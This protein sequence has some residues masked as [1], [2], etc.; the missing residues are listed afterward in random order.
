M[1]ITLSCRDCRT[2]YL[3]ANESSG[4]KLRCPKCSMDLQV[5]G[6]APTPRA[7]MPQADPQRPPEPEPRRPARDVEDDWPRRSSERPR[8]ARQQTPAYLWVIPL[9][10]LL[11]FLVLAGAILLYVGLTDDPD[12]P[13]FAEENFWLD[14]KQDG[15]RFDD[16][17][18][19]KPNF[20]KVDFDFRI[21]DVPGFKDPPLQNIIP[22]Q[23]EFDVPNLALKDAD[24]A[25]KVKPPEPKPK[26][27]P[28]PQTNE[29]KVG[30]SLL[31]STRTVGDLV[32]KEL[33]VANVPLAPPCWD[34]DGSFFYLLTVPGRLQRIRAKDLHLDKETP[35]DQT[36]VNLGLSAEGLVVQ[37]GA[38]RQVLIL[39]PETLLERKRFPYAGTRIIAMSPALSVGYTYVTQNAVGIMDLK[40]GETTPFP[41]GEVRMVSSRPPV[42]T[43]D[44]KYLFIK[45]IPGSLARFRVTGGS[46]VL[47]ESIANLSPTL[48]QAVVSPDGK[49][50]AVMPLPLKSNLKKEVG[51]VWKGMQLSEPPVKLDPM[52]RVSALLFYPHKETMLALHGPME[53]RKLALLSAAGTKVRDYDLERPL[54]MRLVENPQRT[55]FLIQGNGLVLLAE[56]SSK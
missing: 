46:L 25:A 51:L 26:I 4:K 7:A 52:E 14:K 23:P 24:A 20:D 39:D 47:E 54:A 48:S 21:K 28:T 38:S 55:A 56:P 3:L 45:G 6:E 31:K 17:D 36:C 33:H 41:L 32:F 49:T 9:V 40:T 43:E 44:G 22:P 2:T 29:P 10:F 42:V 53:Q 11:L 34:R 30:A 16:L 5:P 27:I 35:L 15:F 8:R 50:V 12:G 13:F 37:T 19:I 18:M 1:A